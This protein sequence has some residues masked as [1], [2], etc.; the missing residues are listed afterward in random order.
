MFDCFVT[1]V[2]FVKWSEVESDEHYLFESVLV[3]VA[4]RLWGCLFSTWTLVLTYTQI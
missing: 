4:D 3:D 1:H 2:L